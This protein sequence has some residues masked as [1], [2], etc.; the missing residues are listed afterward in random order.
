MIPRSIHIAR[1]GDR[2]GKVAMDELAN[3]VKAGLLR[4]DDDYWE[5]GMAD[6]QPL[7][8]LP[9]LRALG[10]SPDAW[11]REARGVMADAAGLLAKGTAR[12]AETARSIAVGGNEVAPSGARKL[13]ADFM[14]QIKERIAHELETRPFLAAPSAIVNDELMERTFG[15]VYDQLPGAVTRFIP[16]D[17][18]LDFCLERRQ[19][20]V[21]RDP[22]A[23]PVTSHA[24]PGRLK[25]SHVRLLA[26]DFEKVV[27]FYRDTLGLAIRFTEPG[28]YAEFDT[29]AALLAVLLRDM[30]AE[31]LNEVSPHDQAHPLQRP[32]VILSVEDVDAV[33]VTLRERGVEFLMPPTSQHAWGVRTTHLQDPEGNLIEI[34]SPL[35]ARSAR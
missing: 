11:K 3:L 31:A 24:L 17:L 35:H 22:A 6:W 23:A 8:R 5:P 28:V 27:A 25:L 9:E 4:P 1:N 19:E 20:L 7:S 10:D 32:V 30:M 29:G 18:F 26:C 33:H 2:I 13:L 16:E 15:A 14:P 34:N 12:L 21:Q